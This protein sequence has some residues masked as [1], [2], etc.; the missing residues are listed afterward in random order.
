MSKLKKKIIIASGGTGGHMFPASSLAN[1]L[2]SIDYKVILTSD[3]RGI[4]YLDKSSSINTKIIN[5]SP[6]NWNKF[7]SSILKISFSIILSFIFLIK[8]RPSLI[9]G[10]GG[11]SSFP[12]CFSAIILR[13]PFIIYEN[14]ILLGKANKYL[15]P[16]AK[17][18]FVSYKEVQGIKKNYNYKI[19]T[20]G[21]IL[22]KE[23]LTEINKNYKKKDIEKF[24]ILVMGGSQAAKN[25]AEILP[26]IFVQYKKHDF[27]FKI[28]QQCLNNQTDSLKKLYDSNK[29]NYELF[30]FTFNIFDYYKISDLVIT[31]AGSSAL[32]EIL[33]YNIPII[34]VPL[35]SAADDHQLIN[36]KYF[37]QKGFGLI[38]EEK[39]LQKELF[40]LLQSIQKDKSILDQ[41]KQ[42]QVKHDDRSVF[43]NIKEELVKIFYED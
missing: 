21:N 41:I 42:N 23:I 35:E 36:A 13:V 34:S 29:L 16:F 26:P 3:N 15:V 19:V 8:N 2:K 31:R 18:I 37:E 33:N 12:I 20:V 27:D 32:A 28:I 17:K 7:I 39:N 11:Y 1:Y 4:K 40:N 10:M 43:K 22:R 5:S 14:N 6:L 38:I 9:I 25:F 30:N 24:T